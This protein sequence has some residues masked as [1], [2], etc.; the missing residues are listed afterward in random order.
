MLGE[1]G[2]KEK[3]FSRCSFSYK[4]ILIPVYLLIIKQ[5]SKKHW[6]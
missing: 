3:E 6:P 1:W 4:P 5:K 2:F